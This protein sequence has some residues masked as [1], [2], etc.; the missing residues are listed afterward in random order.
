MRRSKRPLCT[1]PR[2]TKRNTQSIG[3]VIAMV[4]ISQGSKTQLMA[5]MASMGANN[6]LVQSGAAMSGGI[7]WGSGTEKTL[8]PGDADAIRK[9][10]DDILA[11]APIVQV[12]GQ[13]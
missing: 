8:T 3:A 2:K 13:V 9:Q 10:G 5:T 12:R 1:C 6:V 11:V 7:S 4:E